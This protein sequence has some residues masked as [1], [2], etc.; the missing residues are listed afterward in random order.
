MQAGRGVGD[1]QSQK[2]RHAVDGGRRF[3]V[4]SRLALQQLFVSFASATVTVPSKEVIGFP[5][6]SSTVTVR[7]KELPAVMLAGG[8]CVTTSCD[9][10]RVATPTEDCARPR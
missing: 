6:L 3:S 9:E 10:L 7:P 8:G 5:E 2:R 1:R 4:P